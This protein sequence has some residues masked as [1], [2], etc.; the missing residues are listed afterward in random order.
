MSARRP[1]SCCFC[2]SSLS[3]QPCSTTSV[4]RCGFG[5]SPSF[6]CTRPYSFQVKPGSSNVVVPVAAAPKK[7]KAAPAAALD[8]TA[9][10]AIAAVEKKA[11]ELPGLE[12]LQE[13]GKVSFMAPGT[14]FTVQNSNAPPPNAGSKV[15]LLHCD[16][17]RSSS[18]L[19]RACNQQHDAKF[20]TRRRPT[21]AQKCGHRKC[22]LSAFVYPLWGTG[23][24][25]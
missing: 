14:D 7:A 1:L 11:K 22:N 12:V 4:S 24:T 19:D 18:Y 3:F 9:Q 13:S 5:F 17:Y 20:P 2:V 21:P 16:R 25:A 8:A 6:Y 23:S 15:R 10:A